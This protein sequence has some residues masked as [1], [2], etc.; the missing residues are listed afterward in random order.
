MTNPSKYPISVLYVE[1]DPAI[2][3]LVKLI[4]ERQVETVYVAENGEMGLALYKEHKPD[5]V[6]T[7]V[8]MPVMDGMRMSREIKALDPKVVIIITTA[9]DRV[10]FLLDAIDMGID[11]YLVK[12]VQKEKLQIALSRWAPRILLERQVEQQ[13][14]MIQSMKEQLEAV[15]NSVPSMISWIGSDLRYRG[16]NQY[17]AD[18]FGVL[19][20]ECIG[21]EVGFMSFDNDHFPEFVRSFFASPVEHETHEFSLR[22]SA[23]EAETDERTFLIVAKKYNHGAEAVFAG[24]DITERKRYEIT[25]RRINEE[26]E[27][28]VLQRTAELQQAKELAESANQAKSTFLANMSHELRTPL[29]GILG[30]TSLL[31]GAENLSEKQ[32]EYLRMIKISGETLLHIIND[33]LDISKIEAERLDLEYIPLDLAKLLTE[34]IQFFVPSAQQKGLQLVWT[35]DPAL[36]VPLIGDPTRLKQILTNFLGNALKFTQQGSITVTASV[37][38]R[39]TTTTTVECS[40]ADTG[41]GI[42]PEKISTLFRSF[43]Q[44]DPSFTRKYGGTGLGL[45]IA[46]QL[47]EKMH[48]TVG[49]S[50]TEGVGSTFTFTVCLDNASAQQSLTAAEQKTPVQEEWSAF[51][52]EFVSEYNRPLRILLAEDSPINQMIVTETFQAAERCEVIVVGNGEEAVFEA[53]KQVFDCILMDVQMPKMDGLSATTILRNQPS[54]ANHIPI[55]GLTAHASSD[56]KA[57]CLEAGMDAVV[58]KPINF[59]LLFQTMTNVLRSFPAPLSATDATVTSPSLHTA[60]SSNASVSAEQSVPADVQGLYQAVHG[61]IPVVEKLVA[62]FLAICPAEFESIKRAAKSSDSA[63]L[64]QAAHK[65][66]S[67]V[68]NFG[69]E[70][71]TQLCLALEELGKSN[72]AEQ[73]SELVAALEQELERLQAFF[74]SEAWKN[75][76]KI[77]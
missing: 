47:A 13:N 20:S 11:Q 16:V 58:T 25:M 4:L 61:K 66:R 72:A 39:T 45:A 14:T 48:G 75:N 68:G 12:P 31:T 65:L 56:D 34:T 27:S 41:I 43:T 29:N 2:R 74:R 3:L 35:L 42:P 18:A 44:V 50:S 70:R 76:L 77:N 32:Q 62:H 19:P 22:R 52:R 55:I 54:A 5:M 7:D 26:L 28:R 63:Q 71:S 24:I 49:V 10:D 9:H 64:A 36:S 59:D 37:R 8:A 73:A 57:L 17:M 53:K 21:K 1:D 60:L 38:E 30:L 46:K 51:T 69:A 15:L 33:I 6:I 23:D 67:A 40:V